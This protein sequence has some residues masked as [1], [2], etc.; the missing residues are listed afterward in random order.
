MIDSSLTAPRHRGWTHG[1]CLAAGM[2]HQQKA[3]WMQWPQATALGA[4]AANVA[5]KDVETDRSLTSLR[6]S[7][8]RHSLTVSTAQKKSAAEVSIAGKQD[9]PA[10][11]M[12]RPRP[13]ELGTGTACPCPGMRTRLTSG[14]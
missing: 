8:R 4:G 6:R 10:G 9:Q 3:L 12:Q 5:A 11:R 14:E 7:G 1:R 2:L 13:T